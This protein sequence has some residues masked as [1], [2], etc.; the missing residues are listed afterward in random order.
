MKST[1]M[2]SPSGPA[3]SDDQVLAAIRS[4]DHSGQGAL[5]WFFGQVKDYARGYLTGKYPNL[6]G[7][8]WDTVFSNTD[9]RLLR[10]VRN[11]LTLE[12]G[13]RLSSYYVSVADFAALDVIRER[14]KAHDSGPLEAD[15]V[16]PP[17]IVEDMES[18][19]R[20]AAIR[21]WLMA[22]IGNEDQV[23]V[24]LLFTKGYSHQEIMGY[25][26]YDSEGACRNALLKGKKKIAQYLLAHPDQAQ[27]IR[28]L[29]T[30]K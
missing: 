13:T 25:T 5:Q 9:V 24:L 27:A 1:S 30:D 2:D 4:T 11:G 17:R 6:T 16:E 22:V 18:S 19:E 15:L 28:S 26:H 14:P 3:Y 20:S 12:S 7:A 8:E 23:K 10:R 29:L 21:K